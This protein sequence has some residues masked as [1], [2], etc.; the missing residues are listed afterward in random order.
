MN[1]VNSSI[2]RYDNIESNTLGTKARFGFN[3][4]L[5]F[6]C[7]NCIYDG[8]TDRAWMSLTRLAE[9]N[10]SNKAILNESVLNSICC[11][12]SNGGRDRASSTIDKSHEAVKFRDTGR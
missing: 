8:F 3:K 4:T 7:E 11:R 9:A 1:I 10:A 5:E 12:G 2:G 6:P